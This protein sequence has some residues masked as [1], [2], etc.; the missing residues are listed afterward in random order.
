MRVVKT[1]R[2]SVYEKAMAE[3]EFGTAVPHS[4]ILGKKE[5]FMYWDSGK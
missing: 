1:L 5:A 3:I 2:R 4:G